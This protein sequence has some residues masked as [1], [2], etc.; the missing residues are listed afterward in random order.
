MV[1]GSD[2]K[3]LE[4][5]PSGWQEISIQN[6][7]N[8]KYFGLD[9]SITIPFAFVEDGAQILKHITYSPGLGIETKLYLTITELVCEFDLTNQTYG[10]KYNQLSRLE[11]NLATFS[12]ADYKVTATLLEDGL[13]KYIKANENTVY[14]FPLT[15]G[16]DVYDDGIFLHAT[17]EN[18]IDD[19]FQPGSYQ[20]DNHLIG[21]NQ[22]FTEPTNLQGV[23]G[24]TRQ[25]VANNNTAIHATNN[26]FEKAVNA[27]TITVD[28]SFPIQTLFNS[29]GGITPGPTG[30]YQIQVRR[31]NAAGVVQQIYTMF[32]IPPGGNFNQSVR[33][34]GTQT[35][36]MA[37]GDELYLYS[38][39]TSASASPALMSTVYGVTGDFFFNLSYRYRKP[40]TIC[41]ALR[42]FELGNLLLAKVTEGQYQF[43]P[44]FLMT[45]DANKVFTSGDGIRGIDSAVIKI[46]LS[47]FFGFFDTFRDVGLYVTT[48]GLVAM[49]PKVDMV[50]YTTATNLGEISNPVI[51]IAADQ[52]FNQLKI[53]YPD[54]NVEGVNGKQAYNNIF[55]YSLGTRRV[56]R[57]LDK[58]CD[59][60]SDPYYQEIIRVTFAGQ[61]TTDS[62]LDND[63]CVK[64]I[65][66]YADGPGGSYRYNRLENIGALGLL[67]PETVYNLSIR[68][69]ICLRNNGATINSLADGVL[70]FATSSKNADVVTYSPDY[71]AYI[72]DRDDITVSTLAAPY[73]K[74]F[75]LTFDTA[76]ND[77][78]LDELNA[79]PLRLYIFTLQNEVYAGIPDNV[80]IE[81]S[82]RKAQTYQ[83]L[84]GKLTDVQKLINYSG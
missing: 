63:A 35:I 15:D 22:I 29:S 66:D 42:P 43:D 37:V 46:S 16:I 19:G 53:G 58:V 2:P 36:T 27:G 72:R 8:R 59:I 73:F 12:H 56:A 50:D 14:E 17:V 20:N 5:S 68:P 4:Y 10:Y 6:V 64:H 34:Q 65:L 31:L 69:S 82:T 41:K 24:Q 9:R 38:V 1:L 84:C 74:P 51:T 30:A 39:F 7:R 11:V 44:A 83:L 78:L 52:L 54:K 26:W 28:Y 21:I 25:K 45:L 49:R 55:E 48:A 57:L 13:T 67:E 60:V 75:Y 71:A 32:S 79:N 3:P 70:G 62:K 77:N 81:P 80:G 33:V 40:A 18:L 76:G 61:N 47:Q 23:K